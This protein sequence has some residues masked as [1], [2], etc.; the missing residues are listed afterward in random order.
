MKKA[1]QALMAAFAGF[2]ILSGL[3]HADSTTL[4][5]NYFGQV[6]AGQDVWQT[7]AEPYT[8]TGNTW[9]W[10]DLSFSCAGS[11]CDSGFGGV[12]TSYNYVQGNYVYF[13]GPDVA[14]INFK[15]AVSSVGMGV[16]GLGHISGSAGKIPT[17]LIVNYADGSHTFFSDVVF[18]GDILGERKF[19][20]VFFDKPVTSISLAIGSDGNGLFFDNIRY[21]V[22]A[23]PEPETWAMLAAGLGLV[24]A[25]ARRRRQPGAGSH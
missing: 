23:V 4:S 8:R 11:W 19:F 1:K 6:A 10:S 5:E 20:G 15:Q 9:S 16:W 17:P 22:A 25:A 2:S 3:A 18:D 13:A 24:G 7:L 21:T 14:T 12:S